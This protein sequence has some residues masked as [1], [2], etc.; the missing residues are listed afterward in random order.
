MHPLVEFLIVVVGAYGFFVAY[1]LLAADR[2]IFRARRPSYRDG[3]RVSK[4]AADDGTPITALHLR[5]EGERRGVVLFLH[6][7]AEDLGD[8]LP[9]LEEFQRRGFSVLAIDY[10]GY[11]TTPGRANETNV[12]ADAAAALRHLCAVEDVEAREVILYGRSMGG[13]P[14]VVLATR[15]RVGALILD[16]AFTSAFRVVTRVPILP[17]DRFPN[18]DRLPAVRC[19]LL[20]VHGTTDR[21]VPFSHG[22]RLL[23]AAPP[24]TAH[25][26]VEGAGHNDLVEVAGEAYWEALAEL[27]RLVRVTAQN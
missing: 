24:G 20:I 22:L 6:G 17:C 12:V 4:V 1:A 15:E 9:R 18:V 7:N 2:V 23:A 14:A 13:G 19:P 26:W 3:P 25:L 16:G 10:R 27:A 8:L 21:T 11:G 5:P